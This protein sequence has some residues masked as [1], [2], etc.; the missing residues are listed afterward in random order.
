[1]IFT[2]HR[3]EKE[4]EHVNNS[5]QKSFSNQ[6]SFS[7][8]T[9]HNIINWHTYINK[10]RRSKNISIDIFLPNFIFNINA[11]PQYSCCK[12]IYCSYIYLHSDIS[13][14]IFISFPLIYPQIFLFV[15]IFYIWLLFCEW[16]T[17]IYNYIKLYILCYECNVTN[18]IL[19]QNK[20]NIK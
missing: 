17:I 2:V 10:R 18:S 4:E 8:S 16:K 20:S 5:N 3:E 9:K 13:A 1:M 14:F 15:T 7:I 6:I 12:Y 11:K 19:K